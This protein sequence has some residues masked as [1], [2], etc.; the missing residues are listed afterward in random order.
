MIAGSSV[1]P[2]SLRVVQRSTSLDD[3]VSPLIPGP[4]APS[5]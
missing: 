1:E 4:M 5:R 3:G 2:I